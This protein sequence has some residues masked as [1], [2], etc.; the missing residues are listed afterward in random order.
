MVALLKSPLLLLHEPTS[1]VCSP[2]AFGP[3]VPAD[4]AS[5]ISF[6]SLLGLGTGLFQIPKKQRHL[7]SGTLLFPIRSS[8]TNEMP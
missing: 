5:E 2:R 3:A 7:R 1:T 8:N 4:E 6:S